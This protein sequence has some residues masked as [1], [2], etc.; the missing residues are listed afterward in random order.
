MAAAASQLSRCSVFRR[1]AFFK[2]LER[3]FLTDA[4]DLAV[5]IDD[6]CKNEKVDLTLADGRCLDSFFHDTMT[7]MS[8]LFTVGSPPLRRHITQNTPAA[9]DHRAIDAVDWRI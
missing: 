5:L 3:A 2:A 8:A 1:P 6:I 7:K 4:D 9:V